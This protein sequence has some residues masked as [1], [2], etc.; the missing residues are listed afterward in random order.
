M[1]GVKFGIGTNSIEIIKQ[2]GE[3][4]QKNNF[5]GGLLLSYDEIFFL[6]D[7]NILNDNITY[8]DVIGIYY[9]GEET[10]YGIYEGMPL[11]QVEEILG[12]PNG[13]YISYYSEL[14]AE[15]NM[16]IKYEAGEYTVF[17]EIDD[18]SKTVQ[19]ISI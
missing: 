3:P 7:G 5:M 15:N 6:T 16:I 12:N 13:T 10:M 2:W 19:S 4:N 17:F 9:T 18:E 11:E 8:G 14:Y 1:D